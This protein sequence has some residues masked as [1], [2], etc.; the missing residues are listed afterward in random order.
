[1]VNAVI[2]GKLH[3]VQTKYERTTDTKGIT[4]YTS[5]RTLIVRSSR[6]LSVVLSSPPRASYPLGAPAQIDPPVPYP[7]QQLP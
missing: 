3:T 2:Q 1:M 7:L 6:L 5:P 4:R